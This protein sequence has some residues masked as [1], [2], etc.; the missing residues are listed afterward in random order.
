[1]DNEIDY[2][3]QAPSNADIQE[4]PEV[5]DISIGTLYDVNKQMVAETCSQLSKTK[6]RE[7]K[8]FIQKFFF[9]KKNEFYMLLCNVIRYF[10]LL[11]LEG[12]KENPIADITIQAADEVIRIF[13]EDLDAPIY[14]IEDDGSGEAIEIW[15]KYEDEMIAFFLFP[16]DLGL[17]EIGKD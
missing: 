5:E 2:L 17:I 1:M 13:N 9:D 4:K 15:V 7:K 3:N 16:Y 8:R 6:I 14:S 11:R 12:N 10:T